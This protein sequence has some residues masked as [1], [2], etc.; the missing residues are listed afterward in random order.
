MSD[1]T[2]Q[3]PMVIAKDLDNRGDHF[4]KQANLSFW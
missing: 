3:H 1:E 2:S 4:T